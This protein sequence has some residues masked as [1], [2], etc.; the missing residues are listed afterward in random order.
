MS[1]NG[2]FHRI[3]QMLICL[4]AIVPLGCAARGYERASATSS[5]I[6]VLK[7]ELTAA[8][9]KLDTSVNALDEVVSAE[10]ASKPYENFVYALGQLEGQADTIPAISI[11]CFEAS[12]D[13]LEAS[14]GRSEPSKCRLEASIR[15]FERSA[16]RLAPIPTRAPPVA[17]SSGG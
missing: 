10:S 16:G 6:D 13:R 2:E 7:T 17:C 12:I 9:V 11:R 4:V 15:R 8:K 14:I 3:F 5:S 1:T